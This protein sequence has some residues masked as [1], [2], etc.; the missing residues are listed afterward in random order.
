MSTAEIPMHIDP[1]QLTADTMGYSWA[2]R[3]IYMQLR[4]AAHAQGGSIPNNKKTLM[5]ATEGPS[6]RWKLIRELIAE[7]FTERDGRI[8]FPDDLE[9][10]ARYSVAQSA[11]TRITKSEN[12]TES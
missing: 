5:R 12:G 10:I 7:H 8:F 11:L 9:N 2:E 4:F 1:I 6:N 3:A